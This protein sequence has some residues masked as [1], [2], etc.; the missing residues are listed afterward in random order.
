M[1]IDPVT[2][3]L[4]ATGIKMAFDSGRD[5]INKK[6]QEEVDDE[7]YVR[8]QKQRYEDR[9]WA[10]EDR[11]FM[12][13]YNSPEQQIQRFRDAG[14]NP[15]LI[16]GKFE[17][18]QSAMPRGTTGD[19]SER[20]SYKRTTSVP[21]NIVQQYAA[22]QNLE[23][24]ELQKES[25]Q[26]RNENDTINKDRNY[27]FYRA[28]QQVPFGE[29]LGDFYTNDY[30]QSHVRGKTFSYNEQMAKSAANTTK[31]EMQ[32]K[33]LQTE[34]QYKE[35]LVELAKKNNQVAEAKLKMLANETI[36]KQI[37]IEREK[38]GISK[39]S[40]AMLKFMDEWLNKELGIKLNK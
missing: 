25:M 1:P 16:Y 5:Y 27:N 14:L 24:L 39:N 38:R 40:P 31:Y 33:K 4:I 29:T 37:E 6:D 34:Q 21:D 2:G 18:G 28:E 9:Q 11:D 3:T 8:Q 23:M 17:A 12:N 22:L 35:L 15:N 7:N 26:I 20:K 19:P 30:Y 36:L 10:I 13:Y 32:D